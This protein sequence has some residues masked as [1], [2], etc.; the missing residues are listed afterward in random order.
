M[1]LGRATSEQVLT[2]VQVELVLLV[3]RLAKAPGPGGMAT[4]GSDERS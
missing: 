1:S 4:E 3:K 2:A